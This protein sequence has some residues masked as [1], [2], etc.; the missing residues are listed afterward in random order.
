MGYQGLQTEFRIAFAESRTDEVIS[1]C[2]DLSGAIEQTGM[3][4]EKVYDVLALFKEVSEAVEFDLVNYQAVLSSALSEADGL[5]DDERSAAQSRRNEDAKAVTDAYSEKSEELDRVKKERTEL[6]EDVGRKQSDSEKD[7]EALGWVARK[8]DEKDFRA[9][10][11][12]FEEAKRRHEKA[13]EEA[14]AALVAAAKYRDKQMENVN[15]EHSKRLAEIAG[16]CQDV[17]DECSKMARDRRETVLENARLALEGMIAQ[18]QL[19]RYTGAIESTRPC[20]EDYQPINFESFAKPGNFYLGF[21]RWRATGGAEKEAGK[22]LRSLNC[23][24]VANSSLSSIVGLPYAANLENG[25]QIL[26]RPTD[27]DD[28]FWDNECLRS[29]TLRLLMAYPPGKLQL[30]LIDSFKNGI[31]FS[32]I[33]DIVDKHH[34][35]V[36]SGGVLTEAE[37][38]VQA[39]RSLRSKMGNYSGD[40]GYGRDKDSYFQRESV[41][42]VIINDFPNGFTQ[43]SLADLARLMENGATFGMIFIIGMNP[44]FETDFLDNANYKAV[45]SKT[46]MVRLEGGDPS[47]LVYNDTPFEFLIGDQEEAAANSEAIIRSLHEGIVSS[48]ARAERFSQLFPKESDWQDENAWRRMDSMSGV[49]IP[50]GVSGAS[51]ITQIN[52]GMPGA[53]TLHHGLITGPTG[54]GKSTALHTMIMSMVLNYP[55]DEVQLVLIDFKEGTEFRSYAPYKIPNFRSITTT[56]EPEFAL[57]ALEDVRSLYEQR[58][59]MMTDVLDYRADNSVAIPQVVVIFDEV[60]AL[61]ADGVREDIKQTCL[62]ILTMLV[63]K[64]RAM[65]IHIFLASQSFER[66]SCIQPLMSDMKIR[67]CLKDTDT[68]GILEDAEALRDAPAGSAILNNQ[69]GVAGKNDLFQVCILEDEERDD[70]LGRLSG[71]YAASEMQERY[72]SF[73]PRLLFT[74]IED[75]FHHPFNVFVE[76]GKRPQTN[77][78]DPRLRVGSLLKKEG[79]SFPYRATGRPFDIVLASENMLLIGDNSSVA[80][81][82]FIFSVLSVGL[83]S[84]SRRP[85]FEDEVVLFNFTEGGMYADED[86][87]ELSGEASIESVYGSLPQLVKHV[88]TQGGA[89]RS[90]R[91]HAESESS[92]KPPMEAE[93]DRIYEELQRRKRECDAAEDPDDLVFSRI[94]VMAFAL[95]SALRLANADSQEGGMYSEMSSLA[96][97]QAILDEGPLY[98]VY[99]VAWGQTLESTEKILNFNSVKPTESYFGN[100]VVFSA[101]ETEFQAL[102]ACVNRPATA[103][104]AAFCNVDRN[105]RVYFRP[106]DTPKLGWVEGFRER[107]EDSV[108]Y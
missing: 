57:A 41:Q 80:K 97:F 66:V 61:F 71:I 52:V 90:R 82:L 84:L 43:E 62:E 106:F 27:S 65:G 95:N 37:F 18:D 83:D 33:P 44:T 73:N 69:G 70:L 77:E 11:A 42:A 32:G 55:P 14:G 60:Q 19:D 48:K 49:M 58:A 22:F 87:D 81:S 78:D 54:A 59:S 3:T 36:I 17:K 85:E 40:Q 108:G 63:T 51:K 25:M 16:R 4:S 93:I 47:C 76:T 98:D 10:M 101:S 29:L 30:T 31:S 35:S 89:R 56:T 34:E 12:E 53:N 103:E 23:P 105:E 7:Y 2:R 92:G 72:K 102:A 104:G 75:D 68:G 21:A 1:K 91:S 100:R 74:N 99:S 45:L 26:V 64:G 96:K 13:I 15:S 79:S 107:F 5:L 20:Y 86:D 24:Y 50:L 67:L 38:I 9:D 88:P 28:A 94:F 39:L 8:L 6:I 46:E